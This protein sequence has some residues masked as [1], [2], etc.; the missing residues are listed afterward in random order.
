MIGDF[1]FI[2]PW[3][4]VALV[5]LA[6]LVWAIYR[7]QDAKQAWQGIIAPHLLPFL[8]SGQEEAR[9]FSPLLLIALGWV[10]TVLAISGPTWRREPAPFADD[11]AALAIVVKV[12]PSMMTEDV[13]PSRLARGV[14]KIHDLLAQRR[15][16]KTALIAYAG[17]AHVVMPAT[18]DEGIIDTF[19]QALDPKIMPSDGDAASE[20][21]RLA[22][23]A[24]TDAGGGSVLW[25]ADG[26]APEQTAELAAWRKISTTTVRLLPLLL[27][28]NELEVLTK[29]ASAADASIVRL[30]ADESDVGALAHAAKFSTADS[31]EMSDRWQESGY[32][33]TPLLA[34]LLLPFFRRGWIAPTAAQG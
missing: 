13:Q 15:G 8:L 3:W 25:I 5:P 1:H 31:G 17:T 20:A 19:A 30:T 33:F 7:R 22:D 2:R 27:P 28:G 4:L 21:L 26:I 11:T 18:T 34:S 12:S 32:W 29:A 23:Q 10:V 9:R 14:Q 24:L 6:L 16:A